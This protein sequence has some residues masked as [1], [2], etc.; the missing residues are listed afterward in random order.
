MTDQYGWDQDS[1]ASHAARAEASQ[2]D[3]SELVSGATRMLRMIG[4][5]PDLMR[6]M[7]CGHTRV[8]CVPLI[9]CWRAGK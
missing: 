2:S 4:R 5:T 6:R 9:C 7:P 8:T 3:V 1:M